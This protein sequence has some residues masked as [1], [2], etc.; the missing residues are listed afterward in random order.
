MISI[1][2]AQQVILQNTSVLDEVE[3]PLQQALGMVISSD[4]YAPWDMPG[5]DNSA[6][7]GYAFSHG[8]L[9]ENR[10]KVTGFLPAGIER[11][12]PVA[13]GEAIR[14]MTGAPVPP[15]CDTIV[16][17]EDVELLDDV[18]RLKGT[19]RQGSHIRRKGEN[20]RRGERIIA[21]GAVI[22][23][24]EIGMLASLGRT[25][26]PVY[27]AP[28][29][30]IIATG[31]ELVEAGATPVAASKFN[32]NSYSIAAQIAETCA[33]STI[34]G[35]ARDD[36]DSTRAKIIKGL[37]SD[38]IITSGGVSVGERDYVKEVIQELGGEIVFWKVNMKPGKPFAF[39][40]LN[41]K[42]IFALP[43]NPVAAMVAFEQFVRPALLKMMGHTR[44]LKP[45]IKAIVTEPFGN[46]GDRPQL[47]L[48]RITVNDGAYC[49]AAGADQNSGNLAVMVEAN[50][51]IEL[52]P[53][54]MIT[55]GTQVDVMPLDTSFEMRPLCHRSTS[56]DER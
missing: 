25:S 2:D 47:V 9:Q 54:E 18:I 40:L 33:C 4:V 13:F 8:T 48:S 19:V 20:F 27:R 49:V 17:F 21:S 31:D 23:P 10:L 34:L 29:V 45:V 22:R 44:I 15:G 37:Q 36:M 52:A 16:P 14:I 50:G 38:M 46:K 11:T 53:G 35:I 28:R 30:A 24:Q 41:G 42:A 26:S 51:I 55:P 3:V 5:A 7:D 6:M 12:V 32:S 1:S 43:G 56:T 39:A